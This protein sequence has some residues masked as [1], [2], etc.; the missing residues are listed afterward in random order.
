MLELYGINYMKARKC[1]NVMVD[2]PKEQY[3]P[4]NNGYFTNYFYKFLSDNEKVV[5]SIIENE[6]IRYIK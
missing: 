4:P 5:S 2:E 6:T 1:F 3:L